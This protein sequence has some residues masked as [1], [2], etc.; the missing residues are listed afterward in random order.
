MKREVNISSDSIRSAPSNFILVPSSLHRSGGDY[1]IVV[2][3]SHS[4]SQP[5][6]NHILQ[7][8]ALLKPRILREKEA[9]RLI[10]PV[11]GVIGAVR[12]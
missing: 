4:I 6:I 12:R 10:L 2:D 7:R 9:H 3:I 8:F 5:L 1:L 11:S